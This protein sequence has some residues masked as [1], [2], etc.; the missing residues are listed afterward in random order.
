MS[1]AL[2]G[3]GR[4]GRRFTVKDKKGKC[5]S[6]KLC[7]AASSGGHL[8]ELF[9]LK[10]LMEKYDSFLVTEKTAYRAEFG[11]MRC[12]YLLQ[13]NR[14]EK[15]CLPRLIANTFRSVRILLGERPW[16]VV[17]TGVLATVPL[18]LLCKVF[19]GK[20]IY[21]ETFA[22]VKTPTMTGR[23]L[24]RFADRFYIQWPQLKKYY[25]KAVYC[26]GVY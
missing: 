24:Y 6:K 15:S 5:K 25:P 1:A 8:E 9:M 4:E 22:N 16:A 11:G 19:G 2:S 17:T 12:Y 23:L 7:F 3:A 21:I 13:V 20:L 10:P 26:G 14:R 18:C